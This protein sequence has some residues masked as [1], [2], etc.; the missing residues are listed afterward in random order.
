[1]EETFSEKDLGSL[2]PQW[3]AGVLHRIGP[4]YI[5]PTDEA[6]QAVASGCME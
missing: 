3:A 1:M 4:T 2:L 6:V 5:F